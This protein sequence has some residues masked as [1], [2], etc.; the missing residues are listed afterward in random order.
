MAK[1][2]GDSHMRVVFMG[3]PEFAVP[4]LEALIEGGHDVVAVVTQ[5][6]KPKGRSGKMVY[7]PVK[8]AAVLKDIPVFQP[9]KIKEKEA[10][11]VIKSYQPEVIVVAAFGQIL[12]KEILDMPK[13]GCINIH[14]SLLPKYRGAAPIQWAI[15]KGEKETGITTMYM[16]VGVDTGDMIDK[17]VIPIAEKETGG[18]LQ[19]K[20]AK[21]GGTLILETL[22][23]LQQGIAVRE[24]QEDSI[25]FYAKMLDKKMGN[26]DFNQSAIEIER[27]I[28]GLNPWPSAYTKLNGKLLKIWEADVED[29]DCKEYAKAGE[30]TDIT[31]NAII[32]STGNGKLIIKELQLEGKKRMNVNAFLRGY[33][34]EKGVVLS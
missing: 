2:R 18:S 6:D 12:P 24:V 14:A 33:A 3:T 9:I 22:S 16:D 25:S 32:V 27:L 28:R 11:E 30:I 8:E 4:A 21:L 17:L 26:I 5:P 20:L 34:V 23:K 19:D 10:V 13:H 31:E 7:P 29:T 1:E 15:I